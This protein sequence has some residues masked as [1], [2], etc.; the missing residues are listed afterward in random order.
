MEQIN[1]AYLESIRQD[2]QNKTIDCK[3]CSETMLQYFY[4]IHNL[5]KFIK[6][7]FKNF[8]LALWIKS[9]EVFIKRKNTFHS[10]DYS[11][12]DI[13]WVDFGSNVGGELSY[14]HPCIIVKNEFDKVFVIPCSSSK[15]S[16]AY[17]RTGNLYPEFMIGKRTDGFSKNTAIILNNAKW[18]SKSRILK[19]HNQRVSKT[20]Y[21]DIYN[22]L[23]AM[24]FEP[25]ARLLDI[26]KKSL[27]EKETANINLSEENDLL[28]EANRL[29]QDRV[30]FLEAENQEYFSLL[31]EKT[32]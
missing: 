18:I 1:L 10:N 4:T 24:I 29:L 12:R 11:I 28:K 25:K 27:K 6:N 23:F 3:D 7:T 22:K 31:E 9:N 19:K 8:E 13:V 17:D 14:E 26:T 15:L 21:N 2:R 30:V 20:L 32:S 16:K 5:F